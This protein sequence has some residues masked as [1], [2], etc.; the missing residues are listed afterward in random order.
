MPRTGVAHVV[1]SGTRS[2]ASCITIGQRVTD[3]AAG[4]H[5]Q[6]MQMMTATSRR[7]ASLTRAVLALLAIGTATASGTARQDGALDIDFHG[8]VIGAVEDLRIDSGG[9]S[10]LTIDRV[11]SGR[12]NMLG[13]CSSRL[14]WVGGTTVRHYGAALGLSSRV[15]YE[16]WVCG[17]LGDHRIFRDTRTVDW[18]LF[19]EPDRLDNL[20]ISAQVDNVR[21]LQNDLEQLLNLRVR[22]DVAIPLPTHCGG[23]DC[24]QVVGA[25]EPV[26]DDFRFEDAGDGAVRVTVAFSMASDLGD[27]M[28]C[29]AR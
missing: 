24:D 3:D 20:R 5:D 17:F 27:V 22:E 14:Y 13:G 2:T 11:L 8:L 19:V 12:G 26:V 4:V 23:C 1:A 15:R 16:Q 10:T 9:P 29:L 6:E 21:N 28:G 18:R 7:G 25:L